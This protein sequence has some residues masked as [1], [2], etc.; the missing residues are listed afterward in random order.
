MTKAIGQ[1]K[2]HL[3]D[4]YKAVTHLVPSVDD[5]NVAA[6][7]PTDS[8]VVFARE[9]IVAGVQGASRYDCLAAE[10]AVALANVFQ[11][12]DEPGTTLSEM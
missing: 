10:H 12:F 3:G 2:Q 4:L 1:K 9:L 6:N 7:N 11:C 5:S 8:L